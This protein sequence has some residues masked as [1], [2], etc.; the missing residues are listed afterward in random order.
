MLKL[1]TFLFLSGYAHAVMLTPSN[2]V[3]IRGEINEST[4]GVLKP[5][6]LSDD[7]ETFY[8]VLDT[9]GGDVQVG[10]DIIEALKTKTNIKTITIEAS[11]MGSAIVQGLP[12]ERLM[13]ES[14][15][16]MFH[17]AM[18]TI[19][20]SFGGMLQSRT[21]HWE[22]RISIIEERNSKR[23]GIT[24]KDYRIKVK[25]EI[26]YTS[27]S[28]LGVT[29]DKLITLECSKELLEKETT[30]EINLGFMTMKQTTSS[31][32]LIKNSTPL[33]N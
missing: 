12:G 6:L 18:G 8:V 33:M 13:V 32:P 25:S 23:M 24:L 5:A 10:E 16:M 15:R 11:S 20:G 17:E 7:K 27:K 9:P 30:T 28:A 29:A 21:K 26:W 3:L 14:G 4:Y 19:S 22:E 1:I 31:C 2:H